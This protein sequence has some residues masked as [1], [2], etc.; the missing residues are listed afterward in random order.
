MLLI[1]PLGHP[2]D[3]SAQIEMTE[4]LGGLLRS[5]RFRRSKLD[6]IEVRKS[7]L[8]SAYPETCSGGWREVNLHRRLSRFYTVYRLVPVVFGRF[9]WLSQRPF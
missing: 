8:V 2:P 9:R 6:G 5:L 4:R 3:I 1:V 7:T